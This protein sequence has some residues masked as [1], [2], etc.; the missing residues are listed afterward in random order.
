MS[1]SSSETKSVEYWKE[2]G[3]LK[4]KCILVAEDDDTNFYLLKEY[5][6][7]TEAEI[8]WAQNGIEVC[9]MHKEL[10]N[11]DIILMDL[12]MPEMNGIDAMKK[13]K[14]DCPEI[15]IVALTAYAMSGDREAGIKAG[16]NDYLSKP[17]SRKILMET[18]LKFV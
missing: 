11:V 3:I 2:P 6:N 13:I 5:L 12:Q 14:T 9:Q 7:Y 15:P 16:F 4:S 17:V 8:V 1:D 10:T 18:I